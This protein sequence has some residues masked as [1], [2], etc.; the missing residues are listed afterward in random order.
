MASFRRTL[1]FATLAS[2]LMAL[3][4]P[5]AA[6]VIPSEVDVAEEG[7]VLRVLVTMDGMDA[8][9]E[10]SIPAELDGYVEI[11]PAGAPDS[12]TP[13]TI[14][15]LADNVYE[16][17]ATPGEGVWVVR[18]IGDTPPV[19]VRVGEPPSFAWLTIPLVF[20]VAGSWFV[21]SRVARPRHE[22]SD[23]LAVLRGED[24]EVPPTTSR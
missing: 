18:T 6:K 11:H 21:F 3:A 17:A 9:P 23:A 12:A 2:A 24:G 14:R 13:L 15:W 19:E 22:M 10:D 7:G 20:I 1:L 4:A 8:V 5:A 16:G